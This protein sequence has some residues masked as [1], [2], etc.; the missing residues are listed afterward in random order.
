MQDTGQGAHAAA[1]PGLPSL[2]GSTRIQCSGR[3]VCVTLLLIVGTHA[4]TLQEVPGR[5]LP[6]HPPT[7]GLQRHVG[8][9]LVE[10][11]GEAQGAGE[12][13]KHDQ[14]EGGKKGGFLL[15]ELHILKT[16]NTQDMCCVAKC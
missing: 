2:R 4:G 9:P 8:G 13:G 6:G 1:V 10:G 7:E 3:P 12:Q 5:R 11:A 16:K 14:V 15:D